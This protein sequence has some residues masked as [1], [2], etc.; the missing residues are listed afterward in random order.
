[1]SINR[2]VPPFGQVLER[3]DVI[4]VTM[5]QYDGCRA[6]IFAEP[7]C[8]GAADHARGSH[9]ASVDQYPLSVAAAGLTAKSNVHY[10][11]P[12]ISNVRRNFVNPA[13]LVPVGAI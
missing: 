6:R 2:D 7:F 3:P 11:Q 10:C 9:Y 1:V 5:G 12:L 4:E 13:F 8:R